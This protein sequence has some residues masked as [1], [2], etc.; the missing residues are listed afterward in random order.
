MTTDPAP[1]SPAPPPDLPVVPR[2]GLSPRAIVLGA[3][4]ALVIAGYAALAFTEYE[5]GA[6]ARDE[7]PAS[8]RSANGGYRSFHF[9]HSGYHG[10]K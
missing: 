2:R 4:G 7:L 8:V 9:W 3:F 10:G 6:P 5:P 1:P